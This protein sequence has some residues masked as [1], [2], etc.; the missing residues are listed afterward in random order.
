M[1]GAVPRNLPN[2]PSL[3]RF[4]LLALLAPAVLTAAI[5]WI[6]SETARGESLRQEARASFDR[7]FAAI[8]L[9]AELNGAESS[10]RGYVITGDPDF[11]ARYT[12]SRDGTMRRIAQLSARFTDSPDQL[13]RMATMRET[14]RAKFVEMDRVIALRDTSGDDAAIA[15]VRSGLGKRLMLRIQGVADQ[16]ISSE[17]A[18]GELRV[19]AF[20]QRSLGTIRAIW[21]LIGIG[22]AALF[23]ALVY[24]WRRRSAQYRSDLAAFEAAER[25]ETILNSTVDAL[26]IL[27]PS[28]TIE[29][30]NS[31]AT[32]MLGY[33][34]N[35]L[36]RRDVGVI[37]DVAPGAG[38]FAERSG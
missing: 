10:Q 3:L 1:T 24:I 35:E 31:A 38:S 7:R 25:N 20:R 29:T 22:S 11:L 2:R 19:A 34:A 18:T 12:A 37:A 26:L 33:R 14:A 16:V 27:N 8:E 32:R 4:V 17:V 28:G 21:L 30:L 6:Q 13:R 9:L 36:L 23:V 15:A 5:I